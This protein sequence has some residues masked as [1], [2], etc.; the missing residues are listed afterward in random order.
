MRAGKLTETVTLERFTST[1]DDYGAPIEAWKPYVSVRAQR[2]RTSN[3]EFQAA[4]GQGQKIVTTFRIRHMDG[5][6]LTDRLTHAGVIYDLKGIEP[7]GRRE[8]LDLRCVAS[9]E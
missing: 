4:Y 9:G 1:V 6:V 8:G 7:L 2:L 5:I 3:D